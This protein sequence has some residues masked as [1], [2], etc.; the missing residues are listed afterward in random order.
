[1]C[2]QGRRV[3][4]DYAITERLHCPDMGRVGEAVSMENHVMTCSVRRIAPVALVLALTSA[5]AAQ[6]VAGAKDHP[7]VSRYPGYVIVDYEEQEF[8][9]HTFWLDD[10]EQRV[11]GRYWRIAYEIPDGARKAGPLQIG[12][13]YTNAFTSRGGKRM[14]EDLDAGGGRAVARLPAQGKHIWLEVSVS[15]D[16]EIYELAIVEQAGMAQKVEF[17]ATELSKQL[18]AT[19]SVTLRGVLFETGEAII[20]PESAA[21]LV[22]VATLLTDE[23]ALVLEIQGHT[24]DVGAPDANLRLSRDRA[25]AVKAHL[26]TT[27]GIA[28]SRLT[29]V[30][31]GDTR[32]V[33]DNA[34]AEGRAKNRRVELVKK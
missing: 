32:P 24:D 25:A 18:A 31:F 15:N 8:G 21:L 20:R 23:P 12:R 5:A 30:G 7:L 9:A 3:P 11:E 4:A 13:N 29:T 14:F 28:A 17:T 27:P 22:E 10:V 33:A 16:G 2:L 19:G 26:V 34:T 1:V 6:D